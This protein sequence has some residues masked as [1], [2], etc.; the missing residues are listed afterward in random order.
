MANKKI[1]EVEGI[2]PAYGEK[3][4]EAGIKDTD[5]YL[6]A[7]ATA[8]GREALAEKTGITKTLILKWANMV[9]LFRINGVGGEFAELLEASGVDT[10]AELAQRRPD[11]LAAK[12]A[13]V[14][15]AKKLTRVVPSESQIEGWVAQAKELPKGMS[16]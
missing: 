5:G 6:E 15:E 13:E 9:D 12:M 10:V 1:E 3:L 11:N 16:H 7:A 14:N 2:G 8:K 4:R